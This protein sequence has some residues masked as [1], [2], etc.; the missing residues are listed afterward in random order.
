MQDISIIGIIVAVVV[1]V[2]PVVAV[3]A[4]VVGEV[5]VVVVLVVVVFLFFC[6]FI[7]NNV[8]FKKNKL[9]VLW[10]NWKQFSHNFSNFYTRKSSYICTNICFKT[11][12][13]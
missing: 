12:S 1:L 7:S 6:F 8:F 11:L 3:V 10:E 5:V 2:V 9:K 13:E 4:L